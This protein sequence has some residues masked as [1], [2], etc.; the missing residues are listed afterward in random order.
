VGI[1]EAMVPARLLQ[2]QGNGGS[3]LISGES[4]YYN[5]FN[6][7]AG[8]SSQ[9]EIIQ[10][11]L[12]EARN[13][14]WDTRWKALYGGVQKY[15]KKLVKVGQP[16]LY[17]QK[18]NVDSSSNRSLW[19]QYMQN[20]TAPQTE[21]RTLRTMLSTVTSAAPAVFVIPV[22]KD[23]PAEVCPRPNDDR[24]PNYKLGSIY[25][26]GTSLPGFGMD[27]TKYGTIDAGVADKVNL[28]VMAY[29]PTSKITVKV[30]SDAGE[31]TP[32]VSYSS[33]KRY[34]QALIPL[35]VGKN[36]VSVTCTAENETKRTYKF[37]ISREEG[38]T[39]P[40]PTAPPEET[41]E[42]PPTDSPGESSSEGESGSET[43]GLGPGDIN[44]DG[45][46]N[47]LDIGIQRDTILERM[48]LTDME[49]A[50]ADVD[51]DDRVSILDIGILRDFILE[52][53]DQIVKP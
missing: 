51:S 30:T 21:G 49:F 36:T 6:M 53:I 52:R 20:L 4:G 44:R 38:E 31:I 33:D 23:M 43:A 46:I 3:P 47:I 27:K 29:A 32:D 18:F 42:A 34:S 41:T 37:T 26:D 11:G 7:G 8:G 25:V 45:K 35:T 5:Y 16:S 10:N 39:E 14:G 17:T 9:A 12:Q 15:A 22:Y 50:L 48:T 40:E 19:G 13:E 24:N 28:D 2:E 1:N